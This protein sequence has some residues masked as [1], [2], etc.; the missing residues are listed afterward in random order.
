MTFYIT[1][2]RTDPKNVFLPAGRIVC[3]EVRAVIALEKEESSFYM[4]FM[5]SRSD[6]ICETGKHVITNK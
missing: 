5:E 1:R 4:A 2:M 6:V 3:L